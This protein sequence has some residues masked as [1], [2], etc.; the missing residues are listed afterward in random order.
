MDNKL[1]QPITLFL[2][3]FAFYLNLQYSPVILN[4]NE[5]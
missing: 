4:V 2:D 3:I 5:I 1:D